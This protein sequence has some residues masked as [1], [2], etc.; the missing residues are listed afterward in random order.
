MRSILITMLVLF[1]ASAQAIPVVWT[2]A[3]AVFDDG[4][5]ATGSFTY[6]ADTEIYSDINIVTTAGNQQ[7]IPLY[8]GASYGD[9]N[10]NTIP[11]GHILIYE[12]G[13]VT[14]YGLALYWQGGLSNAG[15]NIALEIGNTSGH[16]YEIYLSEFKQR[17]LTSGTIS[18]IPIPGAVW[19]FG[20]A[21]AG[22][23]W[24]QRRKSI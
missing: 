2:L 7:P 8:P 11:G 18:A 24:L 21:L 10:T 5:I 23:G 9:L 12:T 4:G 3:D 16:S 15:G 1:T 19:L 17:F 20:S 14:D 22:L 6:G 13:T